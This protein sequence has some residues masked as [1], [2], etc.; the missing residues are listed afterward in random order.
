[1]G[2]DA[3]FA[4]YVCCNYPYSYSCFPMPVLLQHTLPCY[5]VPT[6]PRSTYTPRNFSRT[7][8][9]L[10]ERAAATARGFEEMRFSFVSLGFGLL[11]DSP[12]DLEDDRFADLSEIPDHH[13]L[14]I[15]GSARDLGISLDRLGFLKSRTGK[16]FIIPV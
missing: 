4:V 3:S 2:I 13:S 5:T 8:Q 6:L 12:E 10:R 16:V 15:D 11:K 14:G 7:L 9:S 1:M